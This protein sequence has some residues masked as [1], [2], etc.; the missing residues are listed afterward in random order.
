MSFSHF[1][2]R[3]VNPIKTLW[4]IRHGEAED[5]S[6]DGRDVHR[7][8]KES[9][10]QDWEIMKP[11]LISMPGEPM[12]VFASP[13]SR[14]LQTAEL[15]SGYFNSELIIDTN[16]YLATA[17]TLIDRIRSTPEDIY[18]VAIVAHNPGVSGLVSYVVKNS[19][20]TVLQTWGV[21]HC[22]FD[23]PWRTLSE[24]TSAKVSLANPKL[25]MTKTH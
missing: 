3:S 19:K 18:D 9:A 13:A 24:H 16:L 15:I 21:A 10:H 7:D 25:I 11:W 17:D 14:T 22:Q 12:W 6:R 5:A 2:I 23:S 4:I 8:L 20:P 1:G